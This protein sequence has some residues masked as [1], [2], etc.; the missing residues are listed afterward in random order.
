MRPAVRPAFRFDGLWFQ[1]GTTQIHLILTHPE[2]GLPDRSPS[3]PEPSR[4]RH[5]AFEVE[6]AWKTVEQLKS[7]EVPIIAGP[8]HRPDGPLQVYVHDPDGNVIELFSLKG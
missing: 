8:K 7:R 3:A 1:A 4:T 2:S 6:D 5:V